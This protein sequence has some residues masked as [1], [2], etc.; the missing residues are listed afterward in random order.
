MTCKQCK[1]WCGRIL[2]CLCAVLTAFA[3]TMSALAVN[4]VGD[5]DSDTEVTLVDASCIQRK[6]AGLRVCDGF[7]ETAADFDG[8]GVVEITDATY[9]QRWLAGM[10]TPLSTEPPT[11]RSTDEEGW[12]THIYRP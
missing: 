7:N 8:N 4:P 9:I 12:G 6:L 1:R 5:A 10:E 11:Q 3:F 2:I